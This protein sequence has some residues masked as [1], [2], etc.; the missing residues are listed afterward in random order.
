M[1]L[2][3][4]TPSQREA[5]LD[6]A[7][8]AM[9]SDG[10][11]AAAEEE[12]V[13]RLLTAM[14]LTDEYDRQRALDDAVC[15]ISRFTGQVERVQARTRELAQVFTDPEQRRLVHQILRDVVAS[16]GGISA[17]EAQFLASVRDALGV[18]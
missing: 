1:D 4:F 10:H 3:A 8:L 9:Y 7:M 12:R 2:Q 14:S 13:E 15:R 11:L 16:D 18:T 5:L 17:Q 6:L